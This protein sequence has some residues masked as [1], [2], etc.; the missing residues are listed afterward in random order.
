MARAA[1]RLDR[2]EAA[3][4]AFWLMAARRRW[5]AG[6]MPNARARPSANAPAQSDRMAKMVGV[7]GAARSAP[8]RAAL[9][10]GPI[11]WIE[12]TRTW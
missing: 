6:C 10:A 12:A 7:S 8:N 11:P 2:F 4:F 3:L 9:R 1:R 5:A